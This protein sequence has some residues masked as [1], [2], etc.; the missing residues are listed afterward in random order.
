MQFARTCE[1]HMPKLKFTLVPVQRVGRQP[2][3]V[4]YALPTLFAAGNIF[5]GFLAIMRAFEGAITAKAG[6]MDEF[7]H[8]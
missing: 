6:A 2:S 1:H 4:A 8:D 5:L 7:R 3:R